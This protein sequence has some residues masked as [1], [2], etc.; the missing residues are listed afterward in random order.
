MAI[1]RI[2]KDFSYEVVIAASDFEYFD[3][4]KDRDTDRYAPFKN[5]TLLNTGTEAVKLFLNGQSGFKLIPAGTIF[6]LEDQEITY[7]KLV[8]VSSTNQAELTLQLDNDYS[9]KEYLRMIA[10]RGLK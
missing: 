10:N 4:E 7:L 5:A 3:F 1:D 6:T 2:N 9:Q 8:N